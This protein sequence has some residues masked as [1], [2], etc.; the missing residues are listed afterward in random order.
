[1]GANGYAQAGNEKYDLNKAK[2]QQRE[3]TAAHIRF[4]EISKKQQVD[5]E[6]EIGSQA[7]LS[8]DDSAQEMGN[9]AADAQSQVP[10]QESL[11]VDSRSD[12]KVKK[13]R[14]RKKRSGAFPRPD[15]A[16]AE[17][18]AERKRARKAQKKQKRVLK[19]SQGT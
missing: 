17:A 14:K 2:Q 6:A 1:M 7:S 10:A 3:K 16:D 13:G 4:E 19:E 18:N 5:N 9:T 8:S 11:N 15:A 12:I